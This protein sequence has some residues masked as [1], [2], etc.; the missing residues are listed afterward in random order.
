MDRL[1]KRNEQFGYYSEDGT[2]YSEVTRYVEG[3][4]RHVVQGEAIDRLAAYEDTGL[5]P[6]EAREISE[7][8]KGKKGVEEY[9]VSQYKLGEAIRE[10]ARLHELLESMQQSAQRMDDEN[11][12][13]IKERD[14]AAERGLF[15]IEQCEKQA[16]EIKCLRAE[17]ESA[18]YLAGEAQTGAEEAAYQ[19]KQLRA[20]LEQVRRERDAAVA[21]IVEA[22]K[23]GLCEVCGRLTHCMMS[24][25]LGNGA[26]EGTVCDGDKFEWR[27]ASGQEAQQNNE[28]EQEVS[29]EQQAR[30]S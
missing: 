12:R 4:S 19:I 3:K 6:E 15:Y 7:W 25:N 10:N 29:H 8:R 17:I 30:C 21:D 26:E 18:D 2:A 14:D 9:L 13:L 24:L 16:G 28:N 11:L 27:G 5:T 23:S 22:H 1:T 20:E